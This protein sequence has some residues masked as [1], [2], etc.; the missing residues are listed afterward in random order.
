MSSETIEQR[1]KNA[2]NRRNFLKKGAIGSA[3]LGTGVLL[4]GCASSTTKAE[5]SENLKPSKA[6]N[7][8]IL[9]SDGM[10][11]GTLSMADHYIRQKENR[12]SHW[13]DL[14]EKGKVKRSLMDMASEN[15]LVTD[16]AAAGSSWGCGYRVNNGSINIGTEGQAFKPINKWFKEAG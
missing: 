13:I 7:V 12:A 8:I 6:K 9:V 4:P 16:S 5:G 14:Y 10:S 2:F 11:M 3:L 15:S 1:D